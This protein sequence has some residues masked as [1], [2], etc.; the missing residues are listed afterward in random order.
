MAIITIFTIGYGDYFPR[1]LFG[2]ITAVV[3]TFLGVY[4]TSLFVIAINSFLVLTNSEQKSLNL[5]DRL[6]L[7]E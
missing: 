5:L 6:E 4:M 7:K 3:V 1:V 2:K